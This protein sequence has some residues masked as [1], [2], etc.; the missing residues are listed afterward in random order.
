[1]GAVTIVSPA[2]TFMAKA[3]LAL[4]EVLSVTFSVNPKFPTAVGVPLIKPVVGSKLRPAGNEPRVMAHVYGEVP[5]TATKGW[6]YGDPI[7]P[8]GNVGAVLMLR[9]L[10]MASVN[11]LLALLEAL[12]L[13]WT[14]KPKF[15][16]LV[17]VPPRAP[18]APFSDRP[19]GS[20]PTLTDQL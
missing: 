13:T 11:A 17:G 15:P 5:P 19:A 8:L 20:K 10:A 14:V 16:V 2:E 12:S 3:L 4:T 7:A 18:D 1:V 9:P 6:E